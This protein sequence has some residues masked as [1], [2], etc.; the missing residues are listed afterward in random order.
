MISKSTLVLLLSLLFTALA[1]GQNIVPNPDFSLHSQCPT[2]YGQVDY[3]TA[4]HNGTKGTVDYFNACSPGPYFNVP[5]NSLGY[6]NSPSDAM[7]GLI[8]YGW[9]TNYREYPTVSIPALVAGSKYKVSIRVSRAEGTH[10]AA[11]GLGVFFFKN[12]QLD[13]STE[14]YL[15][16]TPQIDYTPYGIIKDTLNWVT[17]TDTFVADS[18]YTHLAIG[19]FKPDVNVNTWVDPSSM[20]NRFAYYY[21]DSI[22][23]ERISQVNVGEIEYAAGVN[24]YPNPFTDFA[25]L[26]LPHD[27]GSS[28]TLTV[29]DLFGKLLRTQHFTTSTVKIEKADLPAGVYFYRIM[30]DSAIIGRGRLTIQ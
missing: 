18:A 14:K 13:T 16:Y 11:E 2:N 19:N 28:Y 15:N 3:A 12:V 21:I 22:S 27:N 8:S 20:L 29:Y 7:I 25:T 1:Q 10:T 23:V 30:G 9:D 6:Q 4:W 26:T 5:G 24:V 17:L